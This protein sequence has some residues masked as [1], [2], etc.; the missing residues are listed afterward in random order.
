MPDTKTGI[1]KF[2]EVGEKLK[3][4]EVATVQVQ[5]I[6]VTDDVATFFKD[7]ANVGTENLSS[8]FSQL[9]ITEANS[10]NELWNGSFSKPGMLYYAPDKT[11][12]ES[13]LVSIITV[14]KGFYALDNSETPKPKFT[15]L[16]GGMILESR[17]PFIMFVSG[18]RLNNL[19]QF[20]KDIKQFTKSQNPVPMFAIQTSIKPERQETKYGFNHVIKFSPLKA[21]G[22]AVGIVTDIE[23]LKVL[24][25]GEGIVKQQF[26]SFIR[27]KSV[28][29]NTGEK[30]EY[31]KP[32][33]TT[34]TTEVSA[35][36]QDKIFTGDINVEDLPF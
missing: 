12:H 25:A 17:K 7:N 19:W 27:E 22:G 14:S 30:I 2:R 6:A 26:E 34:V 21:E 18:T 31:V 23:L 24:R 1:D 5:G 3:N 15:Q 36:E 33:V 28:D 29:P 32:A 4:T 35:K 13:L 9:K 16:V 11:E 10:K 8:G 20:G